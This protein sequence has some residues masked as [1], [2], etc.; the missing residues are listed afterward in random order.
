MEQCSVEVAGRKVGIASLQGRARGELIQ[1]RVWLPAWFFRDRGRLNAT[2]A[3][4]RPGAVRQ[5][6]DPDQKGSSEDVD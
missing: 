2:P 1:S 6:Y 4:K 5:L 3:D